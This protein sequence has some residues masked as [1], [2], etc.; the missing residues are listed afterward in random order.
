MGIIITFVLIFLVIYYR[1]QIRFSHIIIFLIFNC[2]IVVLIGVLWNFIGDIAVVKLNSYSGVERLESM[3]KALIYFKEYPFFGVGWGSVTSHDLIINLLANSGLIGFLSFLF[4]IGYLLK[5]L[6]ALIENV[7]FQKD[8]NTHL[9]IYG[10]AFFVS[11][12]CLLAINLLT[13]FT[14][15]FSHFWFVLGLVISI[16]SLMINEREKLVESE[17]E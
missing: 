14:Y 12:V 13:G 11:F 2:I 9:Q 5:R 7:N 1:N 16:T 6:F 17:C 3:K 15:V 8:K 4:L 10:I